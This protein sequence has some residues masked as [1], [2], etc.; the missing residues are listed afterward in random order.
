[1]CYRYYQSPAHISRT[2]PCDVTL[3]QLCTFLFPSLLYIYY[4]ISSPKRPREPTSIAHF[5]ATILYDLKMALPSPNPP[6]S[7]PPPPPQPPPAPTNAGQGIVRMGAWAR[8]SQQLSTP[9]KKVS[10][11]VL[12]EHPDISSIGYRESATI[13]S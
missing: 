12:H 1:M 11:T 5:R 8:D 13:F 7:P 3:S 4:L 2:F 10:D 6:P 9:S